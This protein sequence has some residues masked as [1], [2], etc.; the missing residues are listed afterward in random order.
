MHENPRDA[1]DGWKVD[2]DGYMAAVAHNMLK[3]VRKLGRRI[4]PPDSA[5]PDA[6]AVA[7][8][9]LAMA[10]AATMFA[11]SPRCFARKNCFIVDPKPAL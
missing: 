6:P 10:N 3:M 2:C 8:A 11:A 9:E 1:A 5:L 4:G 7:S